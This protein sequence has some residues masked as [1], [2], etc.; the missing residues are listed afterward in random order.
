MKP[1]KELPI[2]FR[3]FTIDKRSVNEKERTVDLTFS[4]EYPVDRWWG[5]EI[6]DHTPGSV[7]LERLKNSGALLVMHDRAKQVGVISDAEI[8]SDRRGHAKARFGKSVYAEEIF[9]DVLDEIRKTTSSGYII[10]EMVLEKTSDEGPDQYRITDWEPIE[11][12]LE[13]TPADPTVGVGRSE[14]LTEKKYKVKIINRR[15]LD[16]NEE[17]R[18][19]IED[20]TRAQILKDETDKKKAEDEKRLQETETAKKVEAIRKNETSRAK[21]IIAIGEQF[22]MRTEALSAIT[23]D[24]TVDSFR[25][26]AMDKL[27]KENHI[28]STMAHLDLAEREMKKY[29][30]YRAIEAQVQKDWSK[31][32]FERECSEALSKKL[33]R[34]PRGFY[35]PD[36]ILVRSDL[37]FAQR[38]ISKTGAPGLV[39]TEHLAG[40]FID[41]LRNRTAVIEMGALTLTGLVGDVSIPK[42]TG[43]ATGHWITEGSDTTEST[44]TFGTVTLGPKTVSARVDI[45]RR[46]QLQSSPAVEALTINDIINVLARLIDLAAIAGT[47]LSGQPTGVLNTSG[48]GDVI[49]ASL[50]WN[51]VVEFETDVAEANGDVGSM[52]YL[53]RASVNGLLK[54]REK[55]SNT[56]EFLIKDGMMNGYPVKVSN[57]VPAATMIFGVWSQVLIGF[58]SG[59]D[60]K[61]DEVTL[62]DSGGIVIR[63]FQ[64]ADVGI[65]HAASF[66]ASDEID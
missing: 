61:L 18:K 38:D 50:G 43:A 22:N 14:D 10:H 2:Q 57:Q 4:S 39:A 36:D 31:A 9:Q 1:I 32:G 27:V 55:A 64:D 23:G 15:N 52:A 59:L 63:A 41:L 40:S 19:R 3:D 65:R 62:G 46:M 49:G 16:M 24:V 11:I 58:W 47:G 56:A 21:E 12:S 42:Q 48:I 26:V 17:D 20:E 45:T 7:R 5:R 60:I 51:G 34:N 28:D 35:V 30:F 33:G 13:P 53:T 54:I 44:P 6:L 66:S 29:S 37:L 8:S 25:K